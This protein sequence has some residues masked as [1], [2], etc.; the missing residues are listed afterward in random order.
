MIVTPFQ[1]CLTAFTSFLDDS[2]FLLQIGFPPKQYMSAE[3][4]IKEG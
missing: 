3:Q 2:E 4:Q 1:G